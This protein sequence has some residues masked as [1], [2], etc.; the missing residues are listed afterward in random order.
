MVH[1][2]QLKEMEEEVEFCD[3]GGELNSSVIDIKFEVLDRYLNLEFGEVW[4]RDINLTF[5][6]L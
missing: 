1:A 2:V 4:D 3:G 6:S 5:F